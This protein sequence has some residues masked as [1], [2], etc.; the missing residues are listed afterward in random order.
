VNRGKRRRVE[1]EARSVVEEI[2]GV[3]S[4]AAKRVPQDL[5]ESLPDVEWGKI[6]GMRDRLIHDYVGVDHAIA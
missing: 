2:A 5:R 3:A 6:T 1:E 4:S